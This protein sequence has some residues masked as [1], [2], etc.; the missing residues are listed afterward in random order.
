[1]SYFDPGVGRRL[2]LPIEII[3]DGDEWIAPNQNGWIGASFMD[4][5]SSVIQARMAS[6]YGGTLYF[7]RKLEDVVI[8]GCGQHAIGKEEDP[9]KAHREWAELAGKDL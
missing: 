7:R 2:L 1:M 5:G 3:K 9:Y 8:C 6:Y 4:I